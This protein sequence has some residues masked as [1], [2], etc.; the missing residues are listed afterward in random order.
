[1]FKKIDFLKKFQYF[2]LLSTLIVPKG[3]NTLVS[4]LREINSHENY[5]FLVQQQ[6][7]IFFSYANHVC[8]VP[9]I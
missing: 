7:H 6:L 5:K 1:M 3:L 9:E 2:S 8:V 4:S